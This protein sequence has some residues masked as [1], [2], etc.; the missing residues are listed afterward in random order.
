MTHCCLL[1]GQH[2][3][4]WL[5]PRPLLQMLLPAGLRVVLAGAYRLSVLVGTFL[6]VETGQ[7]FSECLCLVVDFLVVPDDVLGL[8]ADCVFGLVGL[9]LCPK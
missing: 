4:Q 8:K 2:P 5:L 7:S 6:D 9:Q 3:P 1:I